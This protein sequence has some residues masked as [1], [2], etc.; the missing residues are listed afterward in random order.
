VRS[1]PYRDLQVVFDREPHRGLDVGL[2]ETVGHDQRTTVDVRVPYPAA[3]VVRRVF[4]GHDV[5]SDEASEAG[6]RT[7]G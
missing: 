6:D 3:V 7:L 1:A 2:V 5:P 4:G